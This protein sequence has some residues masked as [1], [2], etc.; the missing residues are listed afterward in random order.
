MIESKRGSGCGRR[1]KSGSGLEELA[2]PIILIGVACVA[3]T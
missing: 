2:P 3:L 1:G